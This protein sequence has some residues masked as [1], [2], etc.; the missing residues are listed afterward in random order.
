MVRWV[1]E[2]WGCFFPHNTCLRT[3]VWPQ[4]AVQLPRRAIF[5]FPMLLGFLGLHCRLLIWFAIV[6]F[7]VIEYKF[8]LEPVGMRELGVFFFLRRLVFLVRILI[9]RCLFVCFIVRIFHEILGIRLKSIVASHFVFR[10]LSFVVLRYPWR[11]P[12]VFLRSSEML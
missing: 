6:V 4:F 10:I 12:P 7:I 1:Y 3:D 9:F 11:G 2:F 5:R 8:L